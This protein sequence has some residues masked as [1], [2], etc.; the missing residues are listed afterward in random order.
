M[1]VVGRQIAKDLGVM[2]AED[3]DTSWMPEVIC[4]GDMGGGKGFYI[5][6][7]SWF[8]GDTQILQMGHVP[9]AQKI[10]YKELFFKPGGKVP[11]SGL[12]FA[13]WATETFRF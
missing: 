6:S 12:P 4:I 3:A 5:H 1:R 7:N 9:Y 8:G 11:N 2:S 10:A 13:K